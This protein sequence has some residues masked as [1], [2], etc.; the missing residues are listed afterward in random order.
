MDSW[1]IAGLICVIWAAAEAL[2]AGGDVEHFLRELKQPPWALR[3]GV[4]FWIA[5]AYYGAAFVTLWRLFDLRQTG[6]STILPLI[7][8]IAMMTLNAAW[9]FVFFRRRDLRLSFLWFAPYSFVVLL[10][11]WCMSKID[12]LAACLLLTYSLYLP[13]ALLWSYRV[14][15]LNIRASP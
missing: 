12:A 6:E 14:W 8:L 7:L 9:N 4:E 13:Y 1:L 15:K 10:L 5:F 3:K 2:L 11:L